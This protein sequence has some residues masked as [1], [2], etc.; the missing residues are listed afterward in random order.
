MPV[1]ER[2]GV[3]LIHSSESPPPKEKKPSIRKFVNVV[4]TSSNNTSNDTNDQPLTELKKHQK[5]SAA[6]TVEDVLSNDDYVQDGNGDE[7]K[8]FPS[9]LCSPVKTHHANTK[10][11]QK[12]KPF[13]APA[14][15]APAGHLQ[16]ASHPHPCSHLHPLHPTQPAPAQATPVPAVAPTSVVAHAP[17]PAPVLVVAVP[18][19]VVT[20]AR[21]L[22][23]A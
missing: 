5:I 17:A 13:V 7:S 8:T 6:S 3:I 23:A 14:A 1:P 15:H 11:K 21:A 12:P 20:Q 10:A 2:L 19:P 9:Q 18:V 22:V 4:T 16:A